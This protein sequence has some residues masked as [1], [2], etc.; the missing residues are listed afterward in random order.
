MGRAGKL[1]SSGMSGHLDDGHGELTMQR[2]WERDLDNISILNTVPQCK[3]TIGTTE[4]SPD[5]LSAWTLRS[6]FM[7][8]GWG[9]RTEH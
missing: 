7:R 4:I 3:A 6:S 9:Q 2:G 5:R 8:P 1:D